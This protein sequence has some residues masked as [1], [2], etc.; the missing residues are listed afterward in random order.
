VQRIEFRKGPDF[1]TLLADL[2]VLGTLGIQEDDNL[3]WA[4]FADEVDLESVVLQYQGRKQSSVANTGFAIPTVA[5][6]P[7]LAGERFFI[8]PPGS[9]VLTLDDRIRLEINAH[10]AFGS[11]SHET[12]RLMIEALE[13]VVRPGN[14]LVDVGSGS[15]ILSAAAL[16]LGA[17]GVIACDPHQDAVIQTL[18]HAPGALCFQ[19][20]LDALQSGCA[21]IVAANITAPVLDH[22]AGHIYRV[23]KPAGCAVISGFLTA[24]PP[25]HFTADL[26]LRLNEWSCWICRTRPESIPP[27]AGPDIPIQPFP[28]AWW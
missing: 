7:V 2:W 23:L 27:E 10:N 20:S 19:G 25:T 16:H 6:D 4:F 17:H 12:T 24:A 22:L 14:Q 18:L 13:Q 21:D 1:E 9:A 5:L 3:L 26:G 15:G 28:A 11:G 8:V